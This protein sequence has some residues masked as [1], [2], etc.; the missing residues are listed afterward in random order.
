MEVNGD[1]KAWWSG[2]RSPTSTIV[3]AYRFELPSSA[4]PD[5]EDVDPVG[6]TLYVQ[7]IDGTRWV[8]ENM[9]LPWIR[10]LNTPG[11][12]AG[13][14]LKELGAS[15]W[16]GRRPPSDAELRFFDEM[17]EV[18]GPPREI[19]AGAHLNLANLRGADLSG[20][21]LTEADLSGADLAEADLS[22]AQF[23]RADFHWADLRGANLSGANLTDANLREA[24]L[25]GANLSGANLTRAN[26][27]S[28][29]GLIDLMWLGGNHS[30]RTNLSGAN[31]SGA[32]LSWANLS[33]TGFVRADLRVDFPGADLSG[34]DLSGANLADANL[35]EVNLSGANLSGA[36]LSR[37]YL[38]GAKADV[39]TVWPE[40][41]D[42][43]AAGVIFE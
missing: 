13:K 14:T 35:I 34:T 42:P 19:C 37:A 30:L 20:A 40:G 29:Q 10:G 26:L 27:T 23:V 41:F 8:Y 17:P 4:L 21:D 3:E 9:A 18:T 2:T 43:E 5:T 25:R 38:E 12:S 33:Y 15:G 6:G 1:E 31:L 11:T 7:L 22:G 28:E 24:D 16:V 36:N 39:D 32:N